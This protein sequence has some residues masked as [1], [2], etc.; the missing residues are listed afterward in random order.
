MCI[1]RYFFCRRNIHDRL[2]QAKTDLTLVIIVLLA[3]AIALPLLSGSIRHS[4][5]V[6]PAASEHLLQL[7]SDPYH[8]ST[9]QH[10]TEVEPGTFVFGNTIVA[11][12]QAGRFFDGGASNIGWATSADGG[13]TW[14]HGFLPDITVFATPP[15]SYSRV[16]EAPVA[17]DAKHKVWIISYIGLVT[18]ATANVLVS[19][20]TDGG[21]TWGSPIVVNASGQRCGAFPLTLLAAASMTSSRVSAL[22]RAL[23]GAMPIL[24]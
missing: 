23:P 12:F 7:S 6:A 5:A 14:T 8:N 11:A 19:R 21:L 2:S 1:S 17:Y 10:K 16:T 15:G 18:P 4:Q 3:G 13:K 22:T 20:S 9:S 24:R